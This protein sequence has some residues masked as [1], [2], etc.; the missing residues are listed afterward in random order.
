MTHYRSFYTQ[1]ELYTKGMALC[2]SPVFS[3]QY[4]LD[5]QCG[6]F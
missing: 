1:P 6:W 5:M 4:S 2:A 3:N